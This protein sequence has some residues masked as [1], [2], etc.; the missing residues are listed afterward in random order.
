MATGEKV[1][2]NCKR[3]VTGDK[4]PVCNLNQFSRTFKGVIYV[5]DPTNS[6]VCELLGFKVPG[7]YALWVK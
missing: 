6:E 7:K 4:C 2:K 5:N 1:C 3:F